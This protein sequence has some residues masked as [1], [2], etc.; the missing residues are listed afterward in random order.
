MIGDWDCCPFALSHASPV[1][2][3]ETLLCALNSSVEGVE[4]C[5]VS[6][7]IQPRK[8]RQI[9]FS[10][11]IPQGPWWGFHPLSLEY[12]C[13]PPPPDQHSACGTLCPVVST[14]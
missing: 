10:L 7:D 12:T 11:K 5:D 6:S 4:Q 8:M 3:P 9:L 14:L 1:P 13:R 2:S